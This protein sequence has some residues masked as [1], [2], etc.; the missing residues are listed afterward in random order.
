MNFFSSLKQLFYPE[1]DNSLQDYQMKMMR[2]LKSQKLLFRFYL[3]L[4]MTIMLIAFNDRSTT[5][6]ST[7]DYIFFQIYPD[8]D[9]LE[10]GS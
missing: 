4:L 9:A 5:H 8:S 2:D 6:S 10:A 3:L 1:D 7:L